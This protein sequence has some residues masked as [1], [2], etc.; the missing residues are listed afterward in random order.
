[1]I[2]L[3]LARISRLLSSSTFRWKAIHVAGTN[4]KGSVCAYVSSMLHRGRV[5]CGRFNSPHLID[6]WDCITIDEK[7][8]DENIFREVE[9]QITTRNKKEKIEASE[10]ELLTATAFEIFTQK[11][12]E[13]GI[14]EVGLGGRFDATNILKDPIITI[15]TK[16]GKDHEAFLGNTIEEIAYQKAGIMKEKAPCIVDGT[17]TKSVLQVL[18]DYSVKAKSG[19]FIRVPND[20]NN[21]AA[22][23]WTVLSKEDYESHQQTNICLAY[24]A[25]KQTLSNTKRP[26]EVTELLPAVKD[27]IWPGRL[28][29]LSI[30]RLT[31]RKSDMLLDGA[32]NP[33]S[34]EVLGLYVNKQLRKGVLPVTWMI[35]A[36]AGK[37]LN[38]ML[39]LIIR[40]GDNVVAVEFGPVEGMPWVTPAP[41]DAVLRVASSLCDLGKTFDASA[42]VEQALQWASR[43]SDEGPLVVAGSLYLVS[44]ILRLLKVSDGKILSS[45][46]AINA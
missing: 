43:V 17:N 29:R 9:N 2:E 44:D 19:P 28:Q 20:T 23:I 31:G 11:E 24:E 41:A 32:H 38:V 5:K 27:T 14:V 21:E 7:V 26:I 4:G 45:S 30:E 40:P 22:D 34:A 6:R 10:F 18:E 8:V 3:G 33:Q 15:I 12:V 13:I 36:S 37:D 35:A 1:M 16:I 25:V 42:A 39:P 46:I